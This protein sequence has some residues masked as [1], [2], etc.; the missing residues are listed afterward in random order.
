MLTKSITLLSMNALEI[1]KAVENVY[2]MAEV[3]RSKTN[4]TRTYIQVQDALSAGQLV[5]TLTDDQKAVWKMTLD[6][7]VQ[8]LEK[9][10]TDC[11]NIR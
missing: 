3:V 9:A 5:T 7:L 11:K 8:T 4:D 6:N 2:F 10:H 1:A